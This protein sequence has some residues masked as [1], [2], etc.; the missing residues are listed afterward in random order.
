MITYI[1]NIHPSPCLNFI[2]HL[3]LLMFVE[4]VMGP[5]WWTKSFLHLLFIFKQ[6]ASLINHII[7]YI[8]NIVI[9]SNMK[10]LW[11]KPNIFSIVNAQLILF[12]NPMI[13]FICF[14]NF[15]IFFNAKTLYLLLFSP[16]LNRG[17]MYI[18]IHIIFN[19]NSIIQFVFNTKHPRHTY[20][21]II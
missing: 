5:K 12:L 2:F 20:Y 14:Q 15:L 13:L 21:I 11:L 19:H 18:Y 7:K 1:G 9:H 6:D 17:Y 3:I 8:C 4:V 16:S 10:V